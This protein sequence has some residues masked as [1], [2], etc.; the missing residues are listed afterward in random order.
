MKKT[1]IALTLAGLFCASMSSA[2]ASGTADLSVTGSIITASCTP[3]L[4][5]PTVDLGNIQSTTLV[6][7]NNAN[8]Q[9]PVPVTLTITCPSA[10]TTAWGI[11]DNR[12]ASGKSVTQF[13]LGFTQDGTTALGT[14]MID[15]QTNPT[16]DGTV[17]SLVNSNDNGATWTMPAHIATDNIFSVAASGNQPPVSATVSVYPLKVTATLYDATT[18]NLTDDT[19]LDG[20]AT[21]SLVY[22]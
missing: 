9:D 6:S 4:D 16:R 5:T 18:L 15:T 2:F 14:Y 13:G 11:T 20:S 1:A 21:I 22:L 7:G 8:K 12:A 10:M 17:S 19:P 3:V